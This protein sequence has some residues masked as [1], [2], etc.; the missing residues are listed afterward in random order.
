M[1]FGWRWLW[2]DGGMGDVWLEDI[3]GGGLQVT[4]LTSVG[5]EVKEC[6]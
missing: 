3:G 5:N 4:K 1:G 2:L 6:C